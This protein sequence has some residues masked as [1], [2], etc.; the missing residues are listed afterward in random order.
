MS[1]HPTASHAW[2]AQGTLQR[3]LSQNSLWP[4]G[5]INLIG[6]ISSRTECDLNIQR[7]QAMIGPGKAMA[8]LLP[9]RGVLR[10]HANDNQAAALCEG[11]QAGA[12]HVTTHA[13]P[14][15]VHAPAATHNVGGRRASIQYEI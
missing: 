11:T 2:Q 6:M 8:D 15:D 14:D 10:H 4:P 7:I 1:T 3:S 12:E 5:R 13:L 9:A